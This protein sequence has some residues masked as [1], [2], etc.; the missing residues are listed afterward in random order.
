MVGY[1]YRYRNK[2]NGKVYIGQTTRSPTTR[3]CEH[4]ADIRRGS[5]LYFH[6]AIR[7][8]GESSFEFDILHQIE[9]DETYVELR[10]NEL[11]IKEILC[12][13]SFI[14]G[15]NL[16]KGGHTGHHLKG[17]D[18]K[19]VYDHVCVICDSEF[20]TKNK[21]SRFCSGACE[22]KWRRQNKVN[23]V[24]GNCME[25]GKAIQVDKYCPTKFCSYSCSNRW[26]HKHCP[27]FG[28]RKG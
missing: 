19:K 28:T 25:C 10:L 4:L 23:M 21:N 20:T 15:Y 6:N 2:V 17:V 13:N 16:T 18:F 14:A 27:H 5:N 26:N 1:I 3:K 8:Y 24:P 9:G 7:K 11:E 22:Q 12:H